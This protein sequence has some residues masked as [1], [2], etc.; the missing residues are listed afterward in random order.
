MHV[1]VHI[2]LTL[3]SV[4]H[5]LLGCGGGCIAGTTIGAVFVIG[6]VV[7]VTVLIIVFIRKRRK[8]FNMGTI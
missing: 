8:N 1:V 4:S 2:Y 6:T 5:I 3:M 7:T